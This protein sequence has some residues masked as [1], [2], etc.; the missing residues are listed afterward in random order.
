MASG[1]LLVLLALAFA[2]LAWRL[3]LFAL[4]AALGVAT[5]AA[6]RFFSSGRCSR[7]LARCG[8][9]HRRRHRC[10]DADRRGG[11]DRCDRCGRGGL[12]RLLHGAP[13]WLAPATS[14]LLLHF[15]LRLRS[16]D[17]RAL[18]LPRRPAAAFAERRASGRRIV[19]R[20]YRRLAGLGITAGGHRCGRRR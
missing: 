13:G 2:F 18:L 16:G 5:A 3:A 15:A 6:G 17:F 12:R 19:G 4:F 20:A 9:H 11:S 14:T 10:T 1:R 7:G 8:Q